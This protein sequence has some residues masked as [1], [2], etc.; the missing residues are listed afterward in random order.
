[1]PVTKTVQTCDFLKKSCITCQHFAWWDGD[2]CCVAKLITLQPSVKGEFTDVII[3]S[4]RRNADCNSYKRR[5][6]KTNVYLN[7]FEEFLKNKY[8]REI[9]EL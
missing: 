5:Q 4:L 8:E 7:A 9:E 2:Y 6:S 1:M 3:Y